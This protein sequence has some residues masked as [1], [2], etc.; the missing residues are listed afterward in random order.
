MFISISFDPDGMRD[1][2][3]QWHFSAGSGVFGNDFRAV[4]QCVTG[5]ATS[6]Q[7]ESAFSSAFRMTVTSASTPVQ[8]SL[9]PADGR[10]GTGTICEHPA[11]RIDCLV[12]ESRGTKQKKTS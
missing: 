2:R 10:R 7:S 11:W 6:D 12:A 9:L 5:R 4:Y 8:Y 1:N 3:A